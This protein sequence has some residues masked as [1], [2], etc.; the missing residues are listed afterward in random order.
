MAGSQALRLP[1]T[2]PVVALLFMLV[3]MV[4][5]AATFRRECH[6]ACV[7]YHS[8]KDS[9]KAVQ[10]ECSRDKSCP[11]IVDF[12]GNG[13]MYAVCKPGTE[14][15]KWSKVCVERKRADEL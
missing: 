12:S 1:W 9:L 11:S 13:G 3:L 7:S 10:E 8:F 6:V 2:S 15:R 14:Y 5:D 4:A